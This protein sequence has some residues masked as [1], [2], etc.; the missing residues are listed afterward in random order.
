MKNWTKDVAGF[1][2]PWQQDYQDAKRAAVE[3]GI[4]FKVFD[5]EKDYQAKVVD[6]MIH[7]YEIGRTPNPDIM[8]NQEIK[9][10]LFLERSLE[11]GADL[12]ATGHYARV[13]GGQL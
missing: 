5:F 12:I 13:I 7:E 8:C 1:T 11:E 9:F 2:C 3:I 4:R 6:Y 10:K